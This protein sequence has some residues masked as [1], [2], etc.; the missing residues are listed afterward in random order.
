LLLRSGASSVSYV[1]H[2]EDDNGH[3]HPIEGVVAIADLATGEVVEVFDCGVTPMNDS[4]ANYLP[5]F[6][7]PLR[8]DVAPLTITQPDGPGFTVN[9]HE[10]GQGWATSPMHRG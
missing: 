3:A 8:T 4:C 6:N 5:E 9:G 7:Q 10:I 1:R 2:F